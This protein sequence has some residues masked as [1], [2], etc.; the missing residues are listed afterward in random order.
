MVMVTAGAARVS[1]P[2]E[3]FD[4]NWRMVAAMLAFSLGVTSVSVRRAAGSVPFC[5]ASAC[6]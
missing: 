2:V 5:E 6:S 4:P 3:S 1:V